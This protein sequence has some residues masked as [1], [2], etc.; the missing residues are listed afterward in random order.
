MPVRARIEELTAEKAAAQAAL[1]KLGLAPERQDPAAVLDQVPDL[2]KR[3]CDADN[4]TK[5]ALFDA[6]DLRVVYDKASDRLSIS[7]TLTEAVAAMPRTGIEPRLLRVFTPGVGLEPTTSRLTAERVCQLSY[8]GSC[9]PEWDP[10]KRPSLYAGCR[11]RR[12]RPSQP[13]PRRGNW[14]RRAHFAASARALSSERANP[15]WLNAK[16]FSAGTT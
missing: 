4:A 1:P 5:R 7:A 16:R 9:Y 2:S 14:P 15:R 8:P 3:L 12:K 6:F 13:R 10:G 11:R